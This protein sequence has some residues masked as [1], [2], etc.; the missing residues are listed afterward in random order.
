MRRARARGDSSWFGIASLII[1]Y[2][3]VGVLG[4]PLTARACRKL[5]L[6]A[7]DN[8]MNLEHWEDLRAYSL[9]VDGHAR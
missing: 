1:H 2:V 8:E 4:K 5:H 3:A 7:I 6:V 9:G